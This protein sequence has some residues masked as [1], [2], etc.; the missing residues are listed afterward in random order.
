MAFLFDLETIKSVE[1]ILPMLLGKPQFGKEGIDYG[2]QTATIKDWDRCEYWYN[3]TVN[4]APVRIGISSCPGNFTRYVVRLSYQ[5]QG[6]V[7]FGKEDC[8]FIWNYE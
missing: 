1:N 8:K 7:P 4:T 6:T 5:H 2:M 3:R